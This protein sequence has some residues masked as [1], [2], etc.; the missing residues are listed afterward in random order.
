MIEES[1]KQTLRRL[2]VFT[3]LAL[4]AVWLVLR[5]GNNAGAFL[6]HDL[7]GYN[8]PP[9]SGNVFYIQ[10]IGYVDDDSLSYIR[11]FLSTDTKLPVVILAMQPVPEDHG[12]RKDQVDIDKLLKALKKADY[13]PKD[14]FRVLGIT[15]EDLYYRNMNW[16]F[17]V[18][19]MGRRDCVISLYK[20]F[21]M[22]S[23]GRTFRKPEGELLD[24]YHARIRKILRHEIGHTY[25]LPHC[26][27]HRCA[28]VYD[29]N[30][31]DFDNSGEY[32][33]DNCASLMAL[34][35]QREF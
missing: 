3:I 30:V 8:P 4:P 17:G 9:D 12:N 35:N 15:S 18:G 23:E 1:N 11:N 26:D 25:C 31:N 34:N 19:E 24:L 28:M 13:I 33:C 14:P 22:D 32:F 16:V 2:L 5:Y 6:P 10:P 29:D 27:N 20:L 21:P 7:S